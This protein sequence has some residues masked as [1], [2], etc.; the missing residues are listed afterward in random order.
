MHPR[1]LGTEWRVALVVSVL[2]VAAVL[3]DLTPLLRGPA[4]YPPEW[5]WDLRAGPTSGRW[6]AVLAT[7]AALVVLAGLPS[8]GG[9][10]RAAVVVAAAVAV[11]WMFQLSLVG[12]EAGGRARGR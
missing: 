3:L 8:A 7:G 2:A 12:L 5:R 10:R 9:R 4:P 6:L 11:G 1:R